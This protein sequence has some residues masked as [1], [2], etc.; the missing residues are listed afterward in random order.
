MLFLQARCPICILLHRTGGRDQNCTFNTPFGRYCFLRLPFGICSTPEVFH[1]SLK[2]WKK[3]IVW[4]NSQSDHNSWLRETLKKVQK[5]GLKLNKKKCEFGV[6]ELT[7]LGG[8]LS[9]KRGQPIPEKISV[10]EEMPQVR[11]EGGGH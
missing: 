8:K 6:R 5:S 10:G 7:Y 9:R 11:N 3:G 2:A 1:R 4:G